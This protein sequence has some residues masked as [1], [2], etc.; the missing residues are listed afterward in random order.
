MIPFDGQGK[1]GGP[2]FNQ[3]KGMELLLCFKLT[4]PS[5]KIIWPIRYVPGSNHS[6]GPQIDR[7][8]APSRR[9]S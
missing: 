8:H 7:C 4:L 2:T 3:L 5:V 6:A 1:Y 9:S